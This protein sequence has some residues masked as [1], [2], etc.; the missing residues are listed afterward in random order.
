MCARLAA[1]AL[2]LA[3]VAAGCGNGKNVDSSQ[4]E[5][6]IKDDLS[7]STAEVKSANC[8]DDVKSETG[9]KFSCSV[10]FS[11]GA[12]GKVEVT[13]T[14]SK[15]FTYDLVPGSVKIPGSVAEEQIQKSLATQGAKNAS[16]KCPDSIG[17]KLNTIVTCNVTSAGG[18][19]TGQVT[20]T[21]SAADGTVDPGSVKTS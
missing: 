10:S 19:A 14:G 5:K 3:A 11:T 7:T 21:F 13:Q 15:T 4:V 12:G 17:V 18:N 2:A 8:P 20:F 1:V 16:V 6:G 9:A